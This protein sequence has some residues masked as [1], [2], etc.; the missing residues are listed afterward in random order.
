MIMA[1][2]LDNPSPV[3]VW[4]YIGAFFYGFFGLLAEWKY[5]KVI[6]GLVVLLPF[7]WLVALVLEGIVREGRWIGV[8]LI[9]WGVVHLW[10]K[11]SKWK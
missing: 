1:E 5:A 7:L 6:L 2:L 4:G 9:I 8:L 3:V 10:D 11:I